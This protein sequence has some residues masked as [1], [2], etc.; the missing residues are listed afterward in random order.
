MLNSSF[1][2]YSDACIVVKGIIITVL[3]QGADNS[4]SNS[5]R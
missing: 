5:R 4:S 3:G 1:C 2:D